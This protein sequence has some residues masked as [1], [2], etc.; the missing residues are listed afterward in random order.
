MHPLFR[1]A[2]LVAKNLVT[3]TI[4]NE[5][6]VPSRCIWDG[7]KVNIWPISIFQIMNGNA[8]GISLFDI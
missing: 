8:I 1:V 6:V 2:S 5:P 3:L 7:Y 4:D